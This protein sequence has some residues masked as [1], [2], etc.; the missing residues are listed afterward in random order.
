MTKSVGL[1]APPIALFKGDAMKH[2]KVV[3]VTYS[4]RLEADSKKSFPGLIKDLEDHP[5]FDHHGAGPHGGY[6][7]R[8]IKK[9]GCNG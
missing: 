8:M 6:S 1:K 7:V 4:F 3:N 2:I 5:I 9:G